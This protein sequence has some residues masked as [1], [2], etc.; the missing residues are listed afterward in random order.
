MGFFIFVLFFAVLCF[1]P[2]HSRVDVVS[3]LVW[4]DVS[5]LLSPQHDAASGCKWR[6]GHQIWRVSA[7][8]LS[9]RSGA[10][11]KGWSSSLGF[12]LGANISS[13]EKRRTLQN[14]SQGLSFGLSFDNIS[15]GK[16]IRVSKL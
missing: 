12:G 16:G 14:S 5:V 10:A 15:N 8:I 13:P 7:N 11:D 9:Q 3:R 6:S 4:N 1:F 2:K